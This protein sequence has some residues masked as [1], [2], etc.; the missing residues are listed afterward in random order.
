MSFCAVAIVSSPRIAHGPAVTCVADTLPGHLVAWLH[1]QRQAAGLPQVPD[2]PRAHVCIGVVIMDIENIQVVQSDSLGLAFCDSRAKLSFLRCGSPLPAV[3]FHIIDA[4]LFDIP[5][6]AFPK[7]RTDTFSHSKQGLWRVCTE[8]SRPCAH[9]VMS[10][11]CRHHNE[12]PVVLEWMAR[13]GLTA[14]HMCAVQ[15]HLDVAEL[16]CL[17][18]LPYVCLKF[19]SKNHST[20]LVQT[21]VFKNIPDIDRKM[22]CDSVASSAL[23]DMFT[24]PTILETL[25]SIADYLREVAPRILGPAPDIAEQSQLEGVIQTLDNLM[26]NITTDGRVVDRRTYGSGTQRFSTRYLVRILMLADLVKDDKDLGQAVRFAVECVLPEAFCKQFVSLLP[27][28]SQPS[29]PTVG[30]SRLNL[31]V[32]HMLVMRDINL[33]HSLCEFGLPA[34][35]VLCDASVQGGVDWVLTHVIF[36]SAENLVAAW[37]AQTELIKLRAQLRDVADPTHEHEEDLAQMNQIILRSIQHHTLPPASVGSGKG[38]ATLSHK[39]H[40]VMHAARLELSSLSQLRMFNKSV[41]SMT[42]DLGVEHMISETRATQSL[43]QVVYINNS[44]S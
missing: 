4:V 1:Q 20:H 29:Q 44:L 21:T 23:S 24:K 30:R 12:H 33:A 15:S 35:Y 6:D 5:I 28:K 26:N 14:D 34:R 36:I 10:S 3:M 41:M 43:E 31:D 11:T 38:N 7:H 19:P 27:G 39:L 13:H 40:C 8:L 2:L 25:E 17:N 32:S 9:A 42:T 18:T 22:A 37:C 16:T